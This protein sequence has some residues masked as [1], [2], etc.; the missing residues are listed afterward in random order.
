M[1]IVIRDC[2]QMWILNLSLRLID[3]FIPDVAKSERSELSLARNFVFTHLAG[4]LLAQSISVFLYRSDPDPGFA[5]WTIIS[6]I[7]LFWTLPFVYRWRGN[8]RGTA[9]I[10]VELLAFTSLFGAYF[11]GGVSS[12]F[13]P[14]LIVSL[15]LGFFY[16][17]RSPALVVGLFTFNILMFSG[18]QFLWGFPDIVSKEDLA[19]VGWMSIAVSDDLHVLDGHLLRQHDVEE[20]RD[21]AGDRKPSRDLTAPS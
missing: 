4:P 15:L 2:G 17:S 8:L 14:W 1:P 6:C 5:C 11:Y 19:T 10:S 9:T 12:P 21:R 7:W 16:L 13:L 3:W 20:L 18:A